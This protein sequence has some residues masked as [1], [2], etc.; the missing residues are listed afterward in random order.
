[1]ADN[2]DKPLLWEGFEDDDQEEG[3]VMTSR[4]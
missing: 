1:V 3:D 2:P 4:N